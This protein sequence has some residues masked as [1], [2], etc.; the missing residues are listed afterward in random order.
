V[1]FYHCKVVMLQNENIILIQVTKDFESLTVIGVEHYCKFNP[2][3]LTCFKMNKG[4]CTLSPK[5]FACVFSPSFPLKMHATVV[6]TQKIENG[7][8]FFFRGR[9]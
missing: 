7:Q 1:N 8:N 9:V 3:W 5:F 6:K 4:H 2:A